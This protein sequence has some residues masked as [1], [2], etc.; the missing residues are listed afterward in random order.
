MA[1][2]VASVARTNNVRD[3]ERFSR[4][5]L[6]RTLVTV[7]SLIVFIPISNEQRPS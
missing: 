5:Y 4:R 1:T 3:N 6:K 7:V 2:Q